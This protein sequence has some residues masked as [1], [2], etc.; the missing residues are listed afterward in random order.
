MDNLE[1][2]SALQDL[3]LSS[4]CIDHVEEKHIFLFETIPKIDLRKI[5]SI[6][7]TEPAILYGSSTFEIEEE[8][9][10]L[11]LRFLFDTDFSILLHFN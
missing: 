9:N 6:L 10:C 5:F 2:I 4:N 8:R 3:D 7:R 1:S 11:F